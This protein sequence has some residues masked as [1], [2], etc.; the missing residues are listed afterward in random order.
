LLFRKRHDT[1][2][3]VLDP[4]RH[5]Q[6]DPGSIGANPA[7]LGHRSRFMSWR[8]DVKSRSRPSSDIV[9][10]FDSL[11]SPAAGALAVPGR[12]FSLP[13]P[14]S[15]LDIIAPECSDIFTPFS[16]VIPNH[17]AELPSELQLRIFSSLVV[18]HEL[19]HARCEA[20]AQWTALKAS[21]SR[22]RW[23]GQEQGMRELVKFSRV[24]VIIQQVCLHSL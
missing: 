18:L 12:S 10:S 5:L 6:N 1:A 24:R 19:E 3:A 17:F 20:Q 7:D 23:V 16:T 13:Y 2:D 15:F 14:Q 21:S 22:N 9:I 4:Q 11:T 8:G